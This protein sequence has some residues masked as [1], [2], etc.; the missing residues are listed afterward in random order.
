LP[1][2]QTELPAQIFSMEIDGGFGYGQY[3]CNFLA[4]LSVFDQG[5][6]FYFLRG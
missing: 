4:A 1:V 2:F 3:V 5:D 6:H